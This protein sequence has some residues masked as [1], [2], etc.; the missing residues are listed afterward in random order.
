KEVE[1]NESRKKEQAEKGFDGLTFFV[2]RTLLDAKIEKAED[3]SRKI[4]DAFVEFPNWKKSE[5]VLRELR[6]K[7]TFAIF[8][9]MDDIDQVAS[10]V[11]ELFT[12]LGKVGRI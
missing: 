1:A 4:K 8:S 5:S 11:N 7:V 9:E 3:V 10:I 6:K 12:I 2:Y